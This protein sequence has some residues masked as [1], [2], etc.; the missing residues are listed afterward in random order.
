MLAF[1]LRGRSVSLGK[2]VIKLVM[3]YEGFSSEYGSPGQSGKAS[4]TMMH[5]RG[6]KRFKSAA[7]RFTGVGGVEWNN[8]TQQNVTDPNAA[9]GTGDGDV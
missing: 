4:D 1:Y 5:A 9:A 7:G 3:S 8:T 2:T 6:S